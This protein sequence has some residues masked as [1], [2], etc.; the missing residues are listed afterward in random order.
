MESAGVTGVRI[1]LSRPL[2]KEILIVLIVLCFKCFLFR[3]TPLI[4]A[5][6]IKC[7]ALAKALRGGSYQ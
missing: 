2:I 3:L 4:A 5:L 6:G 1:L 7:C